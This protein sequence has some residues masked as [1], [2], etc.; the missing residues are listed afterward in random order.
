MSRAKPRAGPKGAEWGPSGA[1]RGRVEPT[2][3]RIESGGAEW[4]QEE[5]S[6]S[7]ESRG[8]ERVTGTKPSGSRLA[9]TMGACRGEAAPEIL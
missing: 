9:E 4:C 3:A 8:A 6:V 5:A 2:G 1:E 7:A